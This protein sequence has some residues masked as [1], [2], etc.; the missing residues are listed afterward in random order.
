MRQHLAE[1]KEHLK[2]A[3][4]RIRADYEPESLPQIIAE[5]TS[6]QEPNTASSSVAGSHNVSRAATPA[7]SAS[8]APEAGNLSSEVKSETP[9]KQAATSSATA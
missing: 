6:Q 4:A 3:K 8:R 5:A 9:L 2:L 1:L 7:L